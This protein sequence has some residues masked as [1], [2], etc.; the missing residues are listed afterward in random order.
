MPVAL[1]LSVCNRRCTCSLKFHQNSKSFYVFQCLHKIQSTQTTAH[2]IAHHHK[3]KTSQVFKHLTDWVPKHLDWIKSI[4]SKILNAK[5]LRVEDYA[6]D[7][8]SGLV[9]FDEL[10]ILVVARMYH[11]HIG[12]VLK[13]HVWYTSS[14]EK[15]EDCLFYLLFQGGVQYLDS[16]TGNWG[17]ASPNHAVTVDIT[18]S[19]QAQPMSLVMD[20]KENENDAKNPVH[21]VTLNLSLEENTI[22]Q[23]LDQLNKELDQKLEKLNRE[24]DLRTDKE[25]RKQNLDQSMD[26]TD[27]GASSRKRRKRSSTS[28]VLRS[29]NTSENNRKKPKKCSSRTSRKAA[30]NKLDID[31]DSLLSKK[32]KRDAK[33]KNL[34]E[35]DP[36]LEAF[37][38]AQHEEYIKTLLAPS[39]DKI[40]NKSIAVEETIDTNDGTMVV[41][42]YRLK[43][44]NKTDR[45]FKCQEVGCA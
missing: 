36:I 42:S 5:K 19:P 41:K 17:Y 28:M 44:N 45:N 13:D 6:I 24:L 21:M 34:K 40:T 35:K 37:K 32:R 12:I 22:D 27:L 7:I 4:G 29:T 39:D 30:D 23:K 9:P 14:A 11:I 3:I 25:N 8:T 16:C 18:V 26:S 38:D 33:P 1:I 20:N 15:P 31:L 2:I 10:A 43:R